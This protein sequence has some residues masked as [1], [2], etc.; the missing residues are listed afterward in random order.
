M[1]LKDVKDYYFKM[2]AQYLEMKADIAD[3]EQALKD[4][5]ITEDQLQTALEEVDK[6]KQNYER[7]SYIMYLLDLPNKKSKKVKHNNMN[8][9][10]IAEFKN[11]QADT[12]SIEIENRCALKAFR[13]E[14]KRLQEQQED[15]NK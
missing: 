11:R 7:L 13:E 6:V 10:L 12:E 14:M 2:L 5:F 3:F 1:A 4:G 9:K 15:E 8:K